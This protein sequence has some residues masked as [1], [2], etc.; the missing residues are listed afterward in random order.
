ML[1]DSGFS[2]KL[3]LICLSALISQLVTQTSKVMKLQLKN[4]YILF[5]NDTL[6][7]VL[8]SAIFSQ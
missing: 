7:Q 1:L 3:N 5:T 2:S 6:E 4:M 8:I